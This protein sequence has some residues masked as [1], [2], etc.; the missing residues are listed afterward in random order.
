M[1]IDRFDDC[2]QLAVELEC[3]VEGQREFISVNL[4]SVERGV[5][6]MQRC[7]YLHGQDV[8]YVVRRFRVDAYVIDSDV[9]ID[10][11]YLK[12]SQK[13]VCRDAN[14][15]IAIFSDWNFDPETLVTPRECPVPI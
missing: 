8:F 2:N 10:E 15:V 5:N 13:I 11:T 7:P 12:D 1:F 14:T 4:G 3:F 6:M 9:Q